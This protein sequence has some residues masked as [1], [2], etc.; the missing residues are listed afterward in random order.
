MSTAIELRKV[1]KTYK[2]G[3][4][5]VEALGGVD[6]IIEEGEMVAIMGPSGSGKS[7]LMHIIGLLDHPSEGELLING[8]KVDL[9]MPDAK[10]AKLRSE[11]I[12]FV[13]QTFNLL[14]K[15]SAYENVIMPTQYRKVGKKDREMRA[16][17]LLAE[18]GLAGREKHKPT[19]LSGGQIQRVAIA[20]SLINNPDIILA[21]EPTGNLDS[22]SGTEIMNV[23]LDLNKKGKTVILITHDP[24][25]ADFA[26]RTIR[27][28][29]GKVEKGG[30]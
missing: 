7:T 15:I 18:V 27:I 4:L 29:D 11:K 20:R 14:S 8:N 19:E 10:L 2:T 9:T 25:I 23:L 26:G 3:K 28:L 16:M 30:K 21:D 24:R 12:G 1:K 5:S 13:F 22:K 6:I 17:Q